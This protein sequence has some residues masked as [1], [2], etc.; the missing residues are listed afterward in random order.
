VSEPQKP[1]DERRKKTSRTPS[2][3]KSFKVLVSSLSRSFR[4]SWFAA[5]ALTTPSTR[6][7]RCL[8]LVGAAPFAA[9]FVATRSRRIGRAATSL[10]CP[11]RG[12]TGLPCPSCGAA[13]AF[14]LLARRDPSWRDYNTICVGYA[15]ASLAASG[16]MALLPASSRRVVVDKAEALSD[17]LRG[18]RSL[19]VA[20]VTLVSVPPW[21]LALR[22]AA[23]R[24]A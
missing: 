10:R 22:R 21:V 13:R 18:N 9:A 1:S 4:P 17:R 14:L 3:V 16:G 24:S 5:T 7:S 12:V 15:A 2:S 20:A 19:A 6:S 8:G 23:I 11:I